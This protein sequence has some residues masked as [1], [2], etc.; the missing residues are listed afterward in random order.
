MNKN[1]AQQVAAFVPLALSLFDALSTMVATA[2]AEGYEIPG[3]EQ[4]QAINAQLKAL[5]DLKES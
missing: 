3:A 1:T 4:L 2:T 5:P